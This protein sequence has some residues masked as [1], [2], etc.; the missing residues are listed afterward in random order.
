MKT[1]QTQKHVIDILFLISLL[2]LFIIC[3]VLV[4][5][6]GI[7][8]YRGITV[9]MNHNY[10]TRTA[11]AYI[12]E[13]IQQADTAGSISVTSFG[14]GDALILEQ[15]IDRESYTTY[16]YLH[17]DELCELLTKSAHKISPEAGQP[18]LPCTKFEIEQM[19]PQLYHVTLSAE[20]E[21]DFS[22]YIATHSTN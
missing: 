14:D 8:V 1:R 9:Q 22:I 17:G 6:M 19:D 11:F 3:A 10:D 20:A 13:K 16:I 18:L 15:T 2:G 4:L 7:R 12:T 21:D 5:I